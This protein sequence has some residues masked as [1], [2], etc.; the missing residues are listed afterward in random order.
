MFQKALCIIARSIAGK[1]TRLKMRGVPT[2]INVEPDG[3]RFP[4]LP[5]ARQ[6]QAWRRLDRGAIRLLMIAGLCICLGAGVRTGVLADPG[7]PPPD[8]GAG[9]DVDS[10]NLYFPPPLVIEPLIPPTRPEDELERDPGGILV[11]PNKRAN[12]SP[13]SC[14]DDSADNICAQNETALAVNPT[15]HDNWV[16]GANDYSGPIILDGRA[17]SSC[18]FYST[19]DSGQT[20]DGGLLPTQPGYTGGGDPSLAFDGAGNVYF[21][22]L[23]FELVLPGLDLEDSAIFVFK[24]TD[25]GETFGPPTELVSSA[26]SPGVHDKEFI[27]VG[28]L[29]GKVYVAWVHPGASNVRFAGSDDGAASFDAP[30]PADNV[31]VNDAENSSNQGPVVATFGFMDPDGSSEHVYVAWMDLDQNRI[32]FDR[33]TDGGASFGTDTVVEGSVVQ[34]PVRPVGSGNGTSNRTSLVGEFGDPEENPQSAFRANSFPSMA[35]CNNLSSPYYGHIYIVY[36]DN[37][38]SDGDVFFKRSEDGG[39]TWPGTFTRKVNDDAQ[40]NGKDQF[41][42]WVSVDENCKVNVSFYDRRDDPAN[43]RFHLYFSHSTDSGATFS[44][45][46]R[47]S[48]VASTNAQFLGGFVGDYLQNAATIAGNAEYH[49]DLDRAMTLWMDTRDGAQDAYSGTLLQ[50][51]FG[52]GINVDVDLV[53]DQPATDLDFVFPG[54]VSEDFGGFY[55][56]PANPFQDHEVNYDAGTDRTTLAFVNPSPGPLSPGDL[57]HV[58]F[59]LEAAP[60]VIDSFWTGSGDIGSIPLGTV[61]FAY[62]PVARIATIFVC[63]DRADGK[64]LSLSAPAYAV[65][66]LPI[67]LEDLNAGDLPGALAAQGEALAALPAATSAIAPGACY[68]AEIPEAVAPFEAILLRA[69]LGFADTGARSRAVLFAQK[70][71]KDAREVERA[72]RERFLYVAKLVCGVQPSTTDMRLARGHYATTINLFNAD[73]RPARIEKTLA[74]A[75]PPGWQRPGR[76]SPIGR[77]TVPAGRAIAVDCEDVRRRVFNGAFP[78]S[79]IDG[80]VTIISDRRL[81]VT[82]VYST[83]TLNAE[84]T[85]EDHSSIH[86]EPVAEQIVKPRDEAAL[87][88]LTI[89]KELSVD[90]VC[91]PQRCRVSLRFTVRNV[92]EA[93]AAAFNVAVRRAGTDAVLDDVAVEDGL[94]PGGFFTDTVTVTV[95]VDDGERAICIRADA[96]LD[97]VSESDE[98]NNERCVDF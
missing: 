5:E 8:A 44:P 78:A 19:Q 87:A 90:A 49:H 17:Q 70:I 34:F 66:E 56:G 82:G 29:T 50:T 71:A 21:A 10:S 1:P 77:E 63:N 9:T 20:W 68:E 73:R 69:T 32:L 35:V 28:T 84:G 37:R 91:N 79:F 59:T 3:R 60:E 18:G 62:D 11:L 65:L 52:T 94:P 51:Q 86:V 92:G 25:G 39:Q 4:A 12:A 85:A 24:S 80:F 38:F 95:P 30:A 43:Q 16:G 67:E 54:D 72:P 46:A 13:G 47:V 2:M 40:G 97:Q 83:A 23:N 7:S 42:P 31:F 93:A 22:C 61:D 15:N 27:A 76:V 74:L 88:D 89:D 36:A 64:P 55:H 48:T 57:A 75:I 53:A 26:T 58:G 41:F 33:S 98:G 14:F 45:N 81:T 6:G 96:P